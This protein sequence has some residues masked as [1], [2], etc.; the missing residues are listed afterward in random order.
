MGIISLL[1]EVPLEITQKLLIQAAYAQLYPRN[2]RDAVISYGILHRLPLDEINENL[3]SA[4]EK[5]LC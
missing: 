1:I 5:T 3:F 2:K 4:N